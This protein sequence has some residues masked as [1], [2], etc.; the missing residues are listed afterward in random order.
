MRPCVVDLQVED[1]FQWLHGTVRQRTI[2]LDKEAR[3]LT[4]PT[5]VHLALGHTDSGAFEIFSL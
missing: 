4:L 2:W 5:F 1:F 3:H